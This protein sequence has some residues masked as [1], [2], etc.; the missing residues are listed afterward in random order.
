MPSS[1]SP[2]YVNAGPGKLSAGQVPA[3]AMNFSSGGAGDLDAHITDPIDAHMSWAVGVPELN[4][5]TGQALLS[6]AGGPYDGESVM[7]ALTALSDLLPVKPDRIGYDSPSIPNSGVTNWSNAMTVGGSGTAIHGGFKAGA[8]ARVTKYVTPIGSIGTQTV[9]GTVY[10]ADRGVLAVYKTTAGDFYNPTQTTLVAALWLGAT[11]SAPPGVASAGFLEGTRASGQSNYTSS[12]AGLDTISLTARLPYMT[13][14]PG[15]QYSAYSSNFYAYQLGKYSFPAPLVAGDSGSYLLVHW[16]ETYATTLTSIQPANLTSGNLIAAKCYSAV[17]SDSTAYDNVVRA[18]VFV[19]N[20]SAT[21]PSGTTITSSPTGTLTSQPL[22]GI[23]YYT[24]SAFTVSVIST[25]ANVFSNA[26][27]TNVIASASVAAGYESALPVVQA[28][29]SG[30]N[31]AAYSYPLF[32]GSNVVD[33][34]SASA[35]TLANPPATTSVARF[36]NTVQQT[37]SVVSPMPKPFFPN[38]QVVIRWRGTFSAAVDA[39]SIERYL[40]N[41]AYSDPTYTTETRDSFISEIYR[42]VSNYIPVTGALIQGVGASAFNSATA[43][44]A[45]DLQVYSGRVVYPTTNFSVSSF[46]PAQSFRDYSAIYAADGSGTKRRWVRAF[47]TGISRNTG[48]IQLTGLAA[49]AFNAANTPDSSE[50]ADH[51]GGAIVQIMVPG[52]TGWLDLGRSDGIPDNNKSLDFRGCKV[53]VVEGG[54]VTTVTYSTGSA[55]TAPNSEGDYLIF[56]R[57]TL[58]KNGVGETLS[59][60]DIQWLPP[61]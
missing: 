10:P 15:G 18:N 22:S 48:K 61:T 11:A 7:D 3:S 35:Y 9:T 34:T 42:Y 12:G 59:V 60:Q 58:I 46:Y 39:T 28:V 8:I 21:G 31:G 29:M 5:L 26:F 45:S 16:K 2:T 50:V 44:L 54:G 51:T 37:V 40:V 24:N 38:A 25:A 53:A 33:N 43:L 1:K 49:A 52:S 30:F 13:S 19:D 23:Q 57:V 6:S 55:T 36:F 32:D 20:M 14:Y 27:L 17:P 47:N 4:P 56:V 41:P